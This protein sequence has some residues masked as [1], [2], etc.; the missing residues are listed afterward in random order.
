[1]TLGGYTR[2]LPAGLA[3][4]FLSIGI[5][6]LGAAIAQTM[7]GQLVISLNHNEN[8]GE[9]VITWNGTK[10]TLWYIINVTGDSLYFSVYEDNASEVLAL[11]NNNASCYADIK[12]AGF[13]DAPF[14]GERNDSGAWRA[15]I[16]ANSGQQGYSSSPLSST[17]DAIFSYTASAGPYWRVLDRQGNYKGYFGLCNNARVWYLYVPYNPSNNNNNASLDIGFIPGVAVTFA[18]LLMFLKGLRMVSATRV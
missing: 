7:Q 16:Y 10:W 5:M 4:I 1:M 11:A 14:G 13:Y 18:G 15:T 6:G 2:R 3:I 17:A 8:N 9:D 12:I